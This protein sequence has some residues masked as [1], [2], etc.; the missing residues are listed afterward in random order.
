LRT[1][2]QARTFPLH[3]DTLSTNSVDSMTNF[4]MT[5]TPRS[6]VLLQKLEVYQL[7]MKFLM[8]Y[9]TQKFIVVLTTAHRILSQINP[10]YVTFLYF[11][12]LYQYS[13]TGGAAVG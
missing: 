10:I 11:S 3:N 5:F 12:Q 7:V 4:I 1:E 13:G 6:R 9:G 2:A 8:F